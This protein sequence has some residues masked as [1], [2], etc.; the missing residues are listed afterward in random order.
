M[1]KVSLQILKSSFSEMSKKFGIVVEEFLNQ[2]GE[3]AALI[4]LDVEKTKEGYG[5]CSSKI[6]N[7]IPHSIDEP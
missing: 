2:H 6:N 1:S 4:V 3:K 7:Q 5:E